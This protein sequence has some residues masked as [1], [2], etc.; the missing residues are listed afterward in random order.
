[1]EKTWKFDDLEH[2]KE[3]IVKNTTENTDFTSE[4][5][6]EMKKLYWETNKE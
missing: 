6:Q 2:L 4:R 1:M 3:D 5:V